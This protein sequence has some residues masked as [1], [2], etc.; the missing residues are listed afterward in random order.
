MM[1][2]VTK[3][4]VP[5]VHENR[6]ICKG[7]VKRVRFLLNAQTNEVARIQVSIAISVH[8]PDSYFGSL[9]WKVILDTR[10]ILG[11]K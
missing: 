9:F 11:V 6:F 4:Q 3:K 2:K 10:L 5:K 1:A 7:S 8:I